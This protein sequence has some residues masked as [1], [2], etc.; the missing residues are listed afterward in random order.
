MALDAATPSAMPDFMKDLGL[1][2]PVT[3]LDNKTPE[4]TLVPA[5][6]RRIA[7]DRQQMLATMI[8]MGINRLIV[9]DGKIAASCVF[10]L[11][12]TDSVY[13]EQDKAASFDEHT[14]TSDSGW[15][16]WFFPSSSRDTTADFSVSTTQ[17]TDSTAST[18]MKAKLTGN[19]D[20]NFR[21][22]TFP[23]EKMADLLQI[24]EIEQKAPQ[25]VTPAAPMPGMQLP[26]PPALPP[27]PG[28]P[29][30]GAQPAAPARPAPAPASPDAGG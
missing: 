1:P 29:G 15:R 20:I 16:F 14:E 2:D 11:A 25:A 23:L 4:D 30:A 7:M 19:V 5:A 26:P 22:E 10:E 6:R 18:E 28:M 21:S 3:R 8:L 24:Q 27:L 12:T 13:A 17:H 9:T